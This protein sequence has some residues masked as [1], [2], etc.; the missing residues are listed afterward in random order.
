MIGILRVIL[1]VFVVAG[2]AGAEPALEP[3]A[4]VAA[5]FKDGNWYKGEIDSVDGDTF[6]V[7]SV[8]GRQAYLKKDKIKVLD[9]AIQLK[10]GQPVAA[11]YGSERFYAGSIQKLEAGGAVIKWQDGTAPSF[12][13]SVN[14]IIVAGGYEYK[15]APKEDPRD[16][17]SMTVNG[18]QYSVNRKNGRVYEKGGWVGDYDFAKGSLAAFSSYNANATIDDS[19]SINLWR[20]GT[21]YSGSLQKDGYLY[22][23]QKTLVRLNDKDDNG[24]AL[25]WTE[26]KALALVILVYALR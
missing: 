11:L 24:N 25:G 2:S 8:D 13:K 26:K 18:T 7:N 23:S 6:V 5:Q 9:P 3:G 15:A 17:F 14:I 20:K 1:L 10:T 19:G 22:L 12:V 4:M 21:W 16:L